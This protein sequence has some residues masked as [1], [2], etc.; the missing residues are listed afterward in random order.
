MGEEMEMEQ[1]KGGEKTKRAYQKP[2]LRTITLLAE[3]VLAVGCK[4]LSAPGTIPGL[5]NCTGVICAMPGS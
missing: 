5:A 3:E 2:R 1:G 4:T